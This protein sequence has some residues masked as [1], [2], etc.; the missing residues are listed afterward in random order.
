MTEAF[1]VARLEQEL[2]THPPRE[3]EVVQHLAELGYLPLLSVNALLP[4]QMARAKREFLEELEQS[5]LF[6]PQE[7]AYHKKIEEEHFVLHFLRRATDIDEG[8]TIQALPRHGEKNL[9]SR[10]IH[11]R[12]DLFG[13]WPHPIEVPYTHT[14]AIQ[15]SEMEEYT[16]SHALQA[17]NLM[18]DIEQLTRH[19]L[20]VH[21]EDEFIV[22]FQSLQ[23][24]RELQDKLERRRNFRN[25]LLMDFGEKNE[26]FRHVSQEVLKPNEKKID[27]PFLHEESRKSFKRFVL[28]LIQ[29]HQWQDGFY[30]GVLD[31]K[32]GEVTLQGVLQSI[33]FYNEADKKDIKTHRVLTYLGNNFFMFNALFFL[34]EYMLEEAQE[35]AGGRSGGE[36]K[37]WEQLSA[38]VRDADASSQQSFQAN[39]EKL[40]TD[41][42]T[43]TNRPPQ[44][45]T[46][47]LKRIYFGIKKIIKKAFRFIRKIFNWIKAGVEKAWSF[48]KK[49][50]QGFFDHLS[51]GLKVFIDGLKFLIGKKYVVTQEGGQMI[52]SRF[53]LDGDTVSICYQASTSLIPQHVSQTQ[54]QLGSLQ[55]SMAV[56]G[57]VLKIVLHAL[58]LIAW[59]FILITIVKVFRN[60]LLTYQSIESAAEAVSSLS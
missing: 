38:Q 47:L 57:G 37:V 58:I 42:Y 44:E 21:E 20:S 39:L 60:I 55:F 8:I 2:S 46:G 11:Y 43:E 4:A 35:N 32:I 9:L 50:F 10:I 24:A 48:L 33:D 13:L 59:P 19:L 41:I 36:E 52:V 17:F 3:A 53:H 25:Q 30:D 5:S 31:S 14:T 29:V 56:V 40:K 51:T 16:K 28:R 54:Y 22:T 27:Y 26:F 34:Q 49:L 45:K 18:A 1:L 12:L 6:S 23:V 15:L 7:I